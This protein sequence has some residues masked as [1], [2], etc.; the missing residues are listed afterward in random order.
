MPY[1][2]TV[3]GRVDTDRL[4]M[5]LPH[6][7]V[8]TDLRPHDAPSFGLVE[9]AD[10]VRVMR[11]RLAEAV[12]AGVSAIIECT[13][14]GVGRNVLAMRALSRATGFPLVAAAGTYRE[15]YIPRRIAGL[16]DEQLAEWLRGEVNEGMDGTEIAGG[17]IKAAVS[18]DGITTLEERVLRAAGRVGAQY[19]VTVAS[20][21]TTGAMALQEADILASEGLP[22]ERFVWV[23]AQVEPDMGLHREVVARGCYLSYDGFG[24]EADL[25]A[26]AALVQAAFAGGYQERVLL[27]QDAGWYRP[28]EPGGGA[29]Q[30]YDRLPR[31]LLPHLRRQGLSDDDIRLLT[32]TN[33]KRAYGRE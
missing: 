7:H 5:I 17:F 23:H 10:V 22:P 3:T 29:Q 12:A 24:G 20:H 13:P 6:E 1:L 8:V 2:V 30:P 21:T 16:D 4:G 33:P 15:A 32:D 18:D 19:G 26:Y 9:E 11:P 27:S 31:L 14:A 25:D 28:G